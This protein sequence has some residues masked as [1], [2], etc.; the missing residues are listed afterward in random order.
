M[1]TP[2]LLAL[3]AGL[4]VAADSPENQNNPEGQPR[5]RQPQPQQQDGQGNFRPE[6]NRPRGN[7]Q[8]M[9]P[10]LTPDEM[11]KVHEAL[12]KVKE[13]PAVKEAHEAATEAQKAAGE[14]MKKA[15]EITEAAAIQADPE[16]A[17]LLEKMKKGMQNR[18]PQPPQQ[19]FREPGNDQPRNPGEGNFRRNR[20]SP[21]GEQRQPNKP[22]NG[23]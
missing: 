21:D 20:P 10:A 3:A 17:P 1:K 15:R 16:V 12:E 6:G 14:A 9:K 8:Q 7:M 18:Q 4:A 23:Q 19:N 11:K 2:I 22:D 5:R 13:N